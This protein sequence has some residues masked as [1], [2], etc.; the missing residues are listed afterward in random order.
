MIR[1]A[2][3]AVPD[4]AFAA[5][6]VPAEVAQGAGSAMPSIPATAAVLAGMQVH[7][8]MLIPMGLLC[9]LTWLCWED[10]VA[11]WCLLGP[12]LTSFLPLLLGLLVCTFSLSLLLKRGVERD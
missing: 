9:L 8:Q 10:M 3:A 1:L 6:A 5:P 11:I 2:G 12:L 7:V 4:D